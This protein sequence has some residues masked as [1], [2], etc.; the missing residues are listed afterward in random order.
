MQS[1]QLLEK[2]LSLIGRGLKPVFFSVT[3]QLMRPDR[4]Q[5]AV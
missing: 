2:E 1:Y 4:L 5:L 3:I